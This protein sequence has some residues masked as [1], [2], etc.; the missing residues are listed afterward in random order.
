MHSQLFP[1]TLSISSFTFFLISLFLLPISHCQDDENFWQCFSSFDCGAIKNLTFPFW[2]DNSPEFCRQKDFGLTK[3]DDR[4]EPV[5]SIGGNE[6][7][8]INLNYPAYTM[9]IARNDLW[10]QICLS[11]PINVSLGND[12][13]SY[14]PTN[15]QF[16]L[17]YNCSQPRAP[18]N[19]FPCFQPQGLY[20]FYVDDSTERENYE[21]FFDACRTA[22]KVEVNQSAE[23][24]RQLSLG[25]WRIGFDVVFDISAIFCKKCDSLNGKC[26]NFTSPQ[27][28]ICKSRGPEEKTEEYIHKVEE[29]KMSKCN[30]LETQSQFL[31][32]ER[33]VD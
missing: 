7:R 23:I 9:T 25:F 8:L 6:F 32:Q 12:F 13:L 18:I 22:I 15:R 4:E 16:T 5:I 2:N 11:N 1:P 26:R 3:C 14:P 27:Y 30:P 29:G 19:E 33:I 28:P 10:Q 24:Q 31:E 21:E 17:F 20:S